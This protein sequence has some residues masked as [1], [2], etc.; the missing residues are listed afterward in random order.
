[1]TYR[2]QPNPKT[3][4]KQRKGNIDLNSRNVV[5]DSLAVTHLLKRT[6]I[7]SSI[8]DVNYFIN[9]GLEDSIIYGFSR[10]TIANAQG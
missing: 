4:L 7:G 3:L 1:M 6:T 8:D 5:W 10:L 2:K 9:K